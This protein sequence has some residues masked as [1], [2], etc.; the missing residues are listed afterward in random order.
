MS[1][2]GG[3]LGAEPGWALKFRQRSGGRL[4]GR[5]EKQHAARLKDHRE[6]GSHGGLPSW[7]RLCGQWGRVRW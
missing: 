1:G 3:G 7:R 4:E 2:E 6:R 5:L